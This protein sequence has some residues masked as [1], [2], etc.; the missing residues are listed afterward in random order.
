MK[1]L[2]ERSRLVIPVRPLNI[3]IGFPSTRAAGN[4]LHHES[5]R[6]RVSHFSNCCERQSDACCTAHS[7]S[8]PNPIP[9]DMTATP[10]SPPQLKGVAESERAAEMESAALRPLDAAEQASPVRNAI[11][12]ACRPGPCRKTL[13]PAQALILAASS[14]P[15]SPLV[16]ALA[17][18]RTIG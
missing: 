16:R 13:K 8:S 18:R 15:L 17:S 3:G 7:F 9:S 14:F 2:E 1:R 10:S 11:D 12:H 5:R 6:F 4:L